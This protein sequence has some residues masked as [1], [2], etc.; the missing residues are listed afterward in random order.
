MT[1]HEAEQ[2]AKETI[3]ERSYEDPFGSTI[4]HEKN[5]RS[6]TD[7]EQTRIR[8]L[9]CTGS[10]KRMARCRFRDHRKAYKLD[11]ELGH[12]V[13]EIR[14]NKGGTHTKNGHVCAECRCHHI[15]GY[16]TRGWWF[17]SPNNADG[18]GEVGHYGVGPCFIHSPL[19]RQ[20]AGDLI[21]HYVKR[22]SEEIQ[23]MKEEGL[24]PDGNGGYLVELKERV[25]ES[26]ER[27]SAKTASAAIFR[28]A[29]E[30]ITRLRAHQ[31][32]PQG[33]GF[34]KNIGDMFGFDAT[35]DNQFGPDE[36]QELLELFSCCPL[37]EMA[38]GKHVPMSDKTSIDLQEKLI[39]SMG[40]QAKD[41]FDMHEDEYMH[42]DQIRV[43]FG[44]MLSEV[45]SI[46]GKKGD[47]ADWDRLIL[48]MKEIG[49]TLD[50]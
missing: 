46:Y 10:D 16:G 24:A 22:V 1:K 23:A 8:L 36:R 42:R 15:A 29:D 7:Q 11:K 37:T 5:P 49:R 19:G 47:Q 18:L 6:V 34:F 40:R 14:A 9:L 35:D 31:Q 50:Q 3:L 38:S 28:L 21:K 33:Q 43:A 12:T 44:R 48:E 30:T 39:K 25:K 17:W 20:L 26:E 32:D 41:T 4:K 13:E 2:A 27:L 45:E